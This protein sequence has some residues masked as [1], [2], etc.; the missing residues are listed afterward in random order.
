MSRAKIYTKTGDQGQTRLVDGKTVSKHNLR[1]DAYGTIDELN[2]FL[3]YLRTKLET[4]FPPVDDV[5]EMA[6]S[7]SCLPTNLE[8]PQTLLRSEFIKLNSF[9][10]QLQNQL[11]V[12][13]SLLATSQNET[14]AQLPQLDSPESIEKMIDQ[15]DA[16]L[17]QLTHFIL[18]GGHELASLLHICRTVCRRGERLVSHLI[19]S[20]KTLQETAD[21]PVQKS[22]VY[23]NR[24]S[25][26]FFVSAR[27][28]NLKLNC[29]EVIWK[30]RST[31]KKETSLD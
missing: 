18:P 16:E 3:G 21:H 15:L 7:A 5:A 17:P 1:V 24:L 28:C 4:L 30:A 23:L 9:L 20:E 8:D 27:W 11:F 19:E 2:C 12:M 25:D 6:R 14:L 13:G 31:E 22:L 10:Q 26:F 29:A